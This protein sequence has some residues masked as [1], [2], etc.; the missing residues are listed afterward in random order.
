ME[1][2]APPWPLLQI[3][4]EAKSKADEEKLR[5][6][7]R[8]LA[9][10]NPGFH[11]RWDEESGQTIIAFMDEVE[12]ESIID[13][14]RHEFNIAVNIGT[15][16]VAY[17][18]TITRSHQRDHTH[19]RLFGGAGQFARVV[20]KFEPNSHKADF[21]FQ[22]GIIGD[23]VPNDYVEGVEKGLL[24]AL[25][26]GPFAGFPMIGVKA[27]LVDGDWHQ[28]DSS[29]LAFEIAGRAC[30]REAAPRLGVQ[31]LEPIMKVEVMTPADHVDGIIGEL[32]SRRGHIQDQ[33]T[34]DPDVLINAVVPLATMSKL[35]D[36]LRS[37]S[38]G[39]ARLST[40]YSRYAPVPGFDDREPP[41]AAAMFA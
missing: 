28:T 29:A 30:F 26:A 35:E 5:I 23:A 41:P 40:F 33:E 15:P 16:Q 4:I 18:E 21:A 12:L 37:L 14:V 19:K 22:S 9:G 24:S 38:K 31:L 25:A 27:T 7:L 34:R 3:A 2:S 20:I 1:K 10:G 17:R 32:K 8:R 6:A 39:Q 13:R 36:A 11:V